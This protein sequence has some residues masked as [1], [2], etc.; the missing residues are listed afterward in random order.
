MLSGGAS[1]LILEMVR[2]G[3]AP[4]GAVVSV[5]R[6]GEGRLAITVRLRYIPAEGGVG[7]GFS[8]SFS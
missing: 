2:P 3:Y 1:C 7:G 4:V 8:Q 5:D 6:K